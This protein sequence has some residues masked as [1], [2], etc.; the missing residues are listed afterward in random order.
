MWVILHSGREERFNEVE[1]AQNEIGE[2]VVRCK[3]GKDG[4]YEVFK[5]TEINKIT[6]NSLFWD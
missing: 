2:V 5:I 4:L 1:F 3:D 6:H